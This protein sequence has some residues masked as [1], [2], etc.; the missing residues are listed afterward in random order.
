MKRRLIYPVLG[1]YILFSALVILG[2]YRVVVEYSLNSVP[3]FLLILL[4]IV[5]LSAFTRITVRKIININKND[6]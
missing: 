6:S 3:L 4:T 2:A 5:I 1:Q